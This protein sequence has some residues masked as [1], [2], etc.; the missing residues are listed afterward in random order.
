MT[1]GLRTCEGMLTDPD[2]NGSSGHLLEQGLAQDVRQ[3]LEAFI[4]LLGSNMAEVKPGALDV[5]RAPRRLLS[6]Y[7]TT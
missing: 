6:P 5:C 2:R 7:L 3:P 1:A 4:Q